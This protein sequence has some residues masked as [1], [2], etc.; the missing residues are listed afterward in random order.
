MDIEG[1]FAIDQVCSP[2]RTEFA[3]IFFK[4]YSFAMKTYLSVYFGSMVLA[5]LTTPLVI[6]VARRFNIVDAPDVRKIHSQPVPRIGG[7]SIFVSMMGLIIP[8]LFLT[9][10]IGESIRLIQ[11]K[12]IVLLL[13]AGFIFIV[14]LIDDVWGLGV[15]IKLLAQVFAAIIVC[16]AGVRIDSV[17]VTKSLVIHFGWLSWPITVFWIVGISNAVNFVDGL[18]G[19]AAGICAATCGIIVLL[20]LFFGPAVMTIM[21]LALLGSLS[22]FLI[23]NFNPAKIFMGDSGSLLLGFMIASSSVLCAAKIETLVGLALP[24]LALGIPIFDMLF[25]MLRRFLERRS[26]FSPDFSHFHHRLLALGLRQRHAVVAAYGLTLL[27]AGLGLFMLFTRGAQTIV[28]FV[29]VLVLLFVAFRA[30]GS[31]QLL[32]TIDGLKK[33][34]MIAHQAKEEVESFE[35]IELYFRRAKMFEHWWQAVCFAADK[36]SFI[37]GQLPVTNRNGTK[38]MLTW[39]SNGEC[40][41][42][43]QIV[44]MTL[45]VRDRRAGSALSLEVQVRSN[46]SLESAG[47]RL[48]LFSRLLEQYSVADLIG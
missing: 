1:C 4:F 19:L 44:K 41:G 24:I 3:Q 15:R 35:R 48:T 2:T 38:R 25:S 16:W 8:V 10:V 43:D 22:G 31:V 13:G 9:N 33:K 32:E 21:M 14:G 46:G 42:A 5:V 27:T 34:Y 12:V 20:T 6:R 28:I 40:I 7:V 18:D 47:R 30:V 26:V 39:E 23:F 29:S 36:M 37:K 45:P 11:T 17:T